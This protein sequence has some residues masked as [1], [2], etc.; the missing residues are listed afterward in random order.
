[1]TESDHPEHSPPPLPHGDESKPAQPIPYATPLPPGHHGVPVA[2]RW[3]L[4]CFGYIVLCAIWFFAA[5]FLNNELR[6]P[7]WTGFAGWV[8]MT[9]GLLALTLFLRLRFGYKGYGYG[10]LSVLGA[11]ALLILGCVLLIVAICGKN[12]P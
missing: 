2:G 3:A 7:W 1:M 8:A 12:H 4:G 5:A 9:I 10:I 6:F 11:V